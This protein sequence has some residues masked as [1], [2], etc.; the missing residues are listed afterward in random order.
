MSWLYSRALVEAFSGGGCSDGAPS[1]PSSGNPTPQAYLPPDRMTAFSRPSRFGMTFAPL[2]DDHGAAVLTSF[3]EAF[4]ARTSAWPARVQAL[5]EPDQAC[6]PTWRA[7]L[8]RFD[9]ATSS[10]KTAQRSLLGDSD[11][12]SVIWPRSGMTAGGLCWELPT[13]ERRTKGTGSGLWATP[14]ATDGQRGGSITPNM[15]GV[16][17]AQMINTPSRWP[18]PT[19]QDNVQIRGEGMAAGKSKRGT[20]LAGAVSMWPTPTST[21][22]TNG[23]RVTP[24]KAREGGTLIEA[25]SART[26]WPTPNAGDCKQTGNVNNWKRR[27]AEK[28]ANG[29]NLQ[30]PLAVAVKFATPLSRDYRSGKVRQATHDKNSRPL[31]EQIGGSLNPTWV[32]KLMGWPDDWTSLQHISHVKMCF[33]LMGKHNGTET[34]RN[35]VLRMLRNGDAAQEIQREIGRPVGVHEAALLLAELCEYQNR[36]DEAR[37]FMACAEALEEE[38]RG[39]RLRKGTTGASHRPGQDTQRAGEHPD[40]VQALSRL[41]AHH[42]KTYWQDGRWEDATPRVANGVTA[43]VDRLKAIGNGQVPLCAAT[44]WRLLTA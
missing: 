37:V 10:W 25:L 26:T 7:S 33:W 6:G 38:V 22:G 5:T 32:E 2:T 40:A 30:L 35:E 18:T 16:S 11:E 12:C 27:Q 17:L 43:R 8:A 15:T 19:T 1:A 42:G 23:G 20:T 29:I 21:L 14:S 31:S 9:P 3:L 28:A 41:L 13:L 36:P 34:G 4:P 44:A 39:M 24:T